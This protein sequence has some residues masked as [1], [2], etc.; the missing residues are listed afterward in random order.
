MSGLDVAACTTT[1]SIVDVLFVCTGNTC[2]SPMA[3]A[4]MR[5]LVEE[6]G[7][8]LSVDSAGLRA[9]STIAPQAVR[10]LQRRG[11][12]THE[13]TAVQLTEEMVDRA[14]LVLCMTEEQ[15]RILA[16]AMP[17]SA[18]R[19]FAWGGF[20]ARS[21]AGTSL[22]QD[23]PL[24]RASDPRRECEVLDPV[25][26]DDAA[27]EATAATIETLAVATLHALDTRNG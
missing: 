18:A 19:I 14:S 20:V 10:V 6:R 7:L 12:Q 27:Y 3:E 13:R 11:I 21:V 26:Q 5:R 2:R 17:A 16:E 1:V 25:G 8:T 4:I 15:R 22:P 9:E 24:D 23:R